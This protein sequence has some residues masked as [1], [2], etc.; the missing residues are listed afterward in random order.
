MKEVLSPEDRKALGA[1][2]TTEEIEALEISRRKRLAPL[3]TEHEKE[4]FTQV[5]EQVPLMYSNM[6]IIYAAIGQIKTLLNN[7]R[8]IMNHWSVSEHINKS[9]LQFGI[10]ENNMK[11]VT[12]NL[13]AWESSLLDRL[14][15]DRRLREEEKEMTTR[16]D[17]MKF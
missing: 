15:S 1:V 6:D 11:T 9:E 5:C 7:S 12:E 3:L 2:L 14:E 10:I 17:S 4:V 16:V 8:K 13:R